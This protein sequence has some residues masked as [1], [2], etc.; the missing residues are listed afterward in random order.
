MAAVTINQQLKLLDVLIGKAKASLHKAPEGIINAMRAHG[1]N[2]YY[3][4]CSPSE[5]PGK[6][7]PKK[8]KGLAAALIQRDYDRE[9]LAAAAEE[10][11]FLLELRKANA[12][13]NISFLYDKLSDVYEHLSPA[14]KT[15]IKPY[16][17]PLDQFIREWESFE[18]MGLS[19]SKDTP[20]IYSE[21][22]EKVRSKSEKMIA[23]KLFLMKIP[24]RYECPLNIGR[25]LPVYPDFTILDA[26]ERRE[27]IF[28]HLGMMQDSKYAYDAL[29]KVTDYQ[30]AGYSFGD[31]FFFT[32]E[33]TNS[34]LNMRVFEKMMRERFCD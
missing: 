6:Y 21:R 15:L 34:P 13:R 11:A 14:R 33:S 7:I 17:L 19:F 12:E 1:R 27:V 26:K 3:Y 31:N 5:R 20:E 8:D 4:K 25:Q 29:N 22:G 23:D 9:F 24:Y 32:M 28:E 16:V 2:Q 10:R 18:Y 30:K